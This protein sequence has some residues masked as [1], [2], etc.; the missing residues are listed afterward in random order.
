[1]ILFTHPSF[2]AHQSMPRYASMLQK[3]MQE[4]GHEVVVWSPKARFYKLPLMPSLKKWMGY[5]DQ[6]VLFPIEVKLKLKNCSKD[7]LFIFAD[8]AL[9]PW[10]PLVK[11][12]KHIVHCHDFLALKSALGMIPENPTSFSGKQYQ[13]FIRKGFSKGKNFIAISNKTE[14]DLKQF[15]QGKIQSSSVCYNG[16]SR[17][18]LSI[19]AS[20]AIKLIETKLNL[21]LTDGYIMHIGGNMYYKNRKGVIEIYET[22]RMN[23]NTKIPLLL[24]GEKPSDELLIQRENSEYKKDIHF[25]TDLSDEYINSAY[26]GA[27]CLL[28][29]SLDEGFGW[30]IIEAMAS[31]CPV[32]TVNKAPMNE[33]GGTAAYYIEPIPNSKSSFEQWKKDAA[34]VLE[35]VVSLNDTERKETMKT[36]LQHSK[37]FTTEYSLNAIESVYKKILSIG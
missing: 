37:K 8:Q 23:Y 14:K 5:I 4:R 9:G 18:F 13:N 29:P 28:F 17:P 2:L 22:W 33:V 35:K 31:G 1:M 19:P 12:R 27:K 11:N 7:T 10:V 15:H 36:A 25:I 32:I 3:G 30:P 24:I 26:S 6:Y 20:R 16:L 21:V 34:R